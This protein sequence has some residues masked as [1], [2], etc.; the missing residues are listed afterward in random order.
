MGEQ[1]QTFQIKREPFIVGALFASSILNGFTGIFFVLT[2]SKKVWGVWWLL[3]SLFSLVF[4]VWVERTPYV[5]I[6]LAGIQIFRFPF[7]PPICIK[8]EQIKDIYRKK[9]KVVLLLHGHRRKKIEI[10]GGT[11]KERE[12]FVEIVKEFLREN[13]S[14]EMRS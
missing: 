5:R 3:L 9:Y 2:P 7:Y 1:Q 8:R 10:G 11:K 14:D 4:S 6:T 13:L 12:Y